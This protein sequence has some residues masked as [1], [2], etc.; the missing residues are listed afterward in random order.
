[1]R[2]HLLLAV[3]LAACS[4]P[5]ATVSATTQPPGTFSDVVSKLDATSSTDAASS[6]DALADTSAP[7]ACATDAEAQCDVDSHCGSGQYCDPCARTCKPVRKLCDPC[8]ADHECA[9]SV[10]DGK[11]WSACLSFAAGGSFCG[12][13]C[14]ADAGCGPGYTC[15]AVQGVAVKQCVPKTGVCGGGGGACQSDGQCP[16][17]SVCSADWG[18]CVKGCTADTMCASGTVC[19]LGHCVPPCTGDGD[20]ADLSG[21]AKCLNQK[22]AIPG[23]CLDSS[24]CPDKATHCDLASHLCKPGCQVDG[25]CK[26]AGQA[27]VGGTCKAVGCSQNWQCALGQVC[28]V[29]SGQCQPAGGKHCAVCD[30]NDQQVAACGG[31]PSLCIGFQDQAGADKGHFC[32]LPCGNDPGGPCPQ[33]WACKEI[34]DDKGASQGKFCLRPCYQTPVPTP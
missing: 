3:S 19:A 9:K 10:V 22:C 6:P 31:K 18:V 8:S 30:P 32:A 16:Y 27:C 26:D 14:L 33:G 7:P 17:G 34:K 12:L 2:Y 28:Q 4:Q 5:N 25:D 11:P 15:A 20:C 23:G 1:M 29:A 21:Q 24:E 13:G